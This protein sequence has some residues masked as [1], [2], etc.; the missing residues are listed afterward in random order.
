MRLGPSV[1]FACDSDFVVAVIVV[2]IRD[3]GSEEA[4]LY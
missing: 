4:A 1:I 3:S 2:P